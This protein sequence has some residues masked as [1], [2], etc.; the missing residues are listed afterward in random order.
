MQERIFRGLKEFFLGKTAGRI[1]GSPEIRNPSPRPVVDIY[2]VL[3]IE[4]DAR[5][6]A[7]IQ[8]K[9]SCYISLK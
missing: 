9:S 7:F 3:I 5:E 6:I 2:E 8:K 4:M 1:P